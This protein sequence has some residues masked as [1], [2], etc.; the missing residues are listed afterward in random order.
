MITTNTVDY[1]LL[2]LLISDLTICITQRSNH[3]SIVL[4]STKSHSSRGHE[5]YRGVYT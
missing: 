4:L 3:F 1:R 2:F 5:E